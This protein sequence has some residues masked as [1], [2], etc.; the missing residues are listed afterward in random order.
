MSRIPYNELLEC[1]NDSVNR[2][3]ET[4]HVIPRVEENVSTQAFKRFNK[5]G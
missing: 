2:I 4:L 5:M 1:S 3:I